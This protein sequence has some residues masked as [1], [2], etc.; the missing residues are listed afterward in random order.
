MTRKLA[1]TIAG[2]AA[3]GALTLPGTANADP[4]PPGGCTTWAVGSDG[5]GAR[6]QYGA[7]WVRVVVE[8]WNDYNKKINDPGPWVGVG[9]TSYSYCD[10]SYPYRGSYRVETRSL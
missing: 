9:R 8:C 4:A 1:V 3:F 7:G 5:A 10:G 6:C 2:L